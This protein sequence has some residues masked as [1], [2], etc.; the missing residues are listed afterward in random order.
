MRCK[1]DKKD[2]GSRMTTINLH[3]LLAQE[4]QKQFVLRLDKANDVVRAINCNRKGFLKRV[5]EL[6]KE[7]LCY[8]IIVN[9]GKQEGLGSVAKNI[10]QIDLVP[11]IAGAFT[12][13]IG[14]LAGAMGG[15]AIAT[16]VATVAV[17]AGV[18]MIGK[19]LMPKPE[20]QPDVGGTVAS[21]SSSA[22]TAQAEPITFES[23]AASASAMFNNTTN[24]AAQGAPVPIGYGRLK[25]GSAVI[26][27]TIKSFP[28]SAKTARAFL[29]NPFNVEGQEDMMQ[30]IYTTKEE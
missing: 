28:M 14:A 19:A 9:G 3:G 18:A 30:D 5:N 12:L 24:I 2:E 6:Q 10:K 20:K 16:A 8:T 13:A 21:D 1:Y 11:M 4:Y 29:Q 15:G 7:G 26:Q 22:A 23:R 25:V 17:G 27:G